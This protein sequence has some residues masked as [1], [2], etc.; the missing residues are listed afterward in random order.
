MIIINNNWKT[1]LEHPT[2]YGIVQ[3]IYFH[4]WYLSIKQHC[5]TTNHILSYC[6]L[7]Y[8]KVCMQYRQML[9]VSYNK[10]QETNKPESSGLPQVEDDHW[11]DQ[12]KTKLFAI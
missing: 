11:P 9:K 6:V 1:L 10:C 3:V 7:S 5:A 4:H 2:C 12:Q 8:R